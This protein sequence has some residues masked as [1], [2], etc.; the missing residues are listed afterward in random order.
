MGQAGVR[1]RRVQFAGETKPRT[2]VVQITLHPDREAEVVASGRP[3]LSD[4]EIKALLKVA[5]ASRA[6][7]SRIVDCSFRVVAKIN[8]GDPDAD[9]PLNPPLK[10]PLEQ[11]LSEFAALKT[12]AKLAYLKRWARTEAIPLIAQIASNVEPKYQGVRNLGKALKGVKPEG[13]IDVAALADKNP[14]FWRAMLEMAPGIPLIPATVVILHVADGEIDYAK[15]VADMF[16]TFDRKQSAYSAL[17]GEFSAMSGLFYKDVEGRI[18]EGIELHD[19]G[20]F[21]DLRSPCMRGS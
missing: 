13:A 16:A 3:A 18:K 21:D 10:T 19:A 15:R 7:R 4:P 9:Q 17:L 1:R 11:R 14:D 2:V 8:G 5:D 6:P 12:P 20:K